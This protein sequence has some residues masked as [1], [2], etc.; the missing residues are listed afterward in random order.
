MRLYYFVT[1]IVFLLFFVEPL[2]F[3]SPTPMVSASSLTPG[4]AGTTYRCSP[5]TGMLREAPLAAA[6]GRQ[7]VEPKSR[8]PL[9]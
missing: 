9:L 5:D 3:E 7:L 4:C 6:R 1:S 8:R 2:G